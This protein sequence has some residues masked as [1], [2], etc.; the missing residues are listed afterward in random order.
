MP[1]PEAGQSVYYYREEFNEAF[2]RAKDVM[3]RYIA[4]ISPDDVQS[5]GSEGTVVDTCVDLKEA[6]KLHF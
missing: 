4:D 5:V 3:E 6:M 2:Y 1:D